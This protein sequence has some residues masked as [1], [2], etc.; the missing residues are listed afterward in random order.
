MSLD[1]CDLLVGLEGFHLIAVARRACGLVLNIEPYDCLAGCPGCGVIAQGHGRV[2]VEVIDTPW[3]GIPAWIRRLNTALDMPRTHLPDRDLHQAEPDG[4]R[5][6]GM[7]G[8]PG[9]PLGN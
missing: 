5:P 7:F 1:R 6:Q 4:V 3:A 9:D 2:V 8:H